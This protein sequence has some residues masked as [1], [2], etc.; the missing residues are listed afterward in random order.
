VKPTFFAAPADLRH[1]LEKNHAKTTEL[2]IGFHKKSSG[3]PSVTYPEALDEALSFGWI[4]GVRKSLDDTSYTIRFTPRKPG[5]NWSLVNIKR[6]AELEK[7]GRM[8]PPGL[9]A[10]AQRD[11]AK[12]RQYSYEQRRPRKLDDAYETRFRTH[13][14]AWAFFSAQPPGYQRIAT[15]WVMSAKQEATRLRR[16]DALIALSEKG[17]RLG[18]V[19][20]KKGE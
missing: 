5:S 14:K 7:L 18:I 10:F 17:E 11:E 16:L 9:A 8:K 3:K 15:F 12:A 20:G 13:E 2:W 6:V 1:W 4:D 19:T